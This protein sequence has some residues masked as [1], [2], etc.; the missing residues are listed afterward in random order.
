M[1]RK[2]ES[3][4]ICGKR[5]C[6]NA[7][8][9]GQDLGRYGPSCHVVSLSKKPANKGLKQPVASDRGIEWAIAVNRS[10]IVAPRKV[11]NAVFGAVPLQEP[12]PERQAA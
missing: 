9:A 3:Q 1:E 6:R 5:A 7:L 10:R 11:L 12:E 8:R 4:L 2:T